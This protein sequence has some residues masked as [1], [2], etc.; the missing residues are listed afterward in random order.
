MT[1]VLFVLIFTG[2]GFFNIYNAIT[3]PQ[4]YQTYKE[5]AVLAFYREFI[6]GF[7]SEHTQLFILIIGVGQLFIGTFLIGS[8]RLFSMGVIG[9][10]IFLVAIAPLGFGSAF[11]ATLLMVCAL[12]IIRW[13][14]IRK[15][16]QGRITHQQKIISPRVAFQLIIFIVVIP[17]L[18]LLISRSWDWWEAWVY[19][20]INIA[21]FAVSRALA[22]RRYPDLIA[23]RAQFM[24]HENVFHWDKILAPMVGLGGA[25]I[26]LVAGLDKLLAW[27]P[28]FGMPVKIIALVIILAGYILG[29]Y[30]L[31][32]NRFFSGMVRIQ[33]DRGHQVISSG[34]YRWMR[35]PGYTGA[36]WLYLAT[37]F[38]LDSGW[39][40]I[41][42]GFLV[43]LLVI[44]TALE[45]KA[46][47]VE[48][49]GYSDYAYRVRYRLMPGV[50]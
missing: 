31:I 27:S 16:R 23:E 46:L 2:A 8:G 5:L 13:R 50:W 10:T 32:E 4:V 1:R 43:A 9:G 49:K 40:F 24:R 42:A 38:F 20:F 3:D 34:P 33:S 41:P 28:A 44:R 48:L 18:P 35:H 21:G 14:F 45:D 29:S 30:A 11:P 22:A 37:P 17:F 26:P 6:D 12:F 47:R 19:G 25:L 15:Q 39:V 7:F 36:I